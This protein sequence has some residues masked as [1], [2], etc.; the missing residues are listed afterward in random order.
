TFVQPLGASE[1]DRLIPPDRRADRRVGSERL[2]SS[3]QRPQ[4][5]ISGKRMPAQRLPRPIDRQAAG[6]KRLHF[7]L[8]ELEESL[9][10]ALVP[11]WLRVL[12]RGGI[13]A[14]PAGHV[15]AG[16]S[17]DTDDHAGRHAS[18]V[19]AAAH[20]PRCLDA[21]AEGTL[22][23]KQVEYWPSAVRRL[24][25]WP[26]DEHAVGIAALP[27]VNHE[28]VGALQHE[29]IAS[30]ALGGGNGSCVVRLTNF[31]GAPSSYCTLQSIADLRENSG[32]FACAE[33]ELPITPAN[34][35]RTKV[36]R[37]P[38]T[39]FVLIAVLLSAVAAFTLWRG[40]TAPSAAPG[41]AELIDARGRAV[42]V[43]GPVDRLAIDDS[44]YL[45]ALGLLHP[46][47]VSLLVAWPH[48]VNRLGE[49]T[50]RQFLQKS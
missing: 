27:V 36:A 39:V 26:G 8:Q 40:D 15:V 12:P 34:P 45:V 46:D 22:G 29:R 20:A 30:S 6:N 10:L 28:A 18:R 42:T 1:Q 47:P 37:P 50:Y 21:G 7:A 19:R 17:R 35:P 13:V 24:P 16:I 44:R 23:I 4:H 48:D 11:G 2:R 5:E 3:G 43:D 33:E 32:R 49:D 31:H 14:L 25:Q 9:R 38:F 41:N